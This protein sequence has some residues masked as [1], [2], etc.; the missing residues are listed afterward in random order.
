VNWAYVFSPA[1]FKKNI[2]RVLSKWRLTAIGTGFDAPYHSDARD[3]KERGL[4]GRA[5][6]Q[7]FSWPSWTAPI[8]GVMVN[9]SSP[10]RVVNSKMVNGSTPDLFPPTHVLNK[11]FIP[12]AIT[13]RRGFVPLG[14]NSALSLQ[15]NS[16]HSLMTSH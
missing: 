16:F 8:V 13:S 7:G 6:P 14:S 5:S 9:R 15:T 4:L 1:W 11:Y 2:T 10:R 3:A 12:A